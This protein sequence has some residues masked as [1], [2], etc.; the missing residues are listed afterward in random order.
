[1]LE[2]FFC[3]EVFNLMIATTQM[4]EIP[5]LV[6]KS[7]THHTK[8][9]A[10]VIGS[11]IRSMFSL[12]EL[13]TGLPADYPIPI[14]IVQHRCK[15]S[16]NLLEEV[17]QQ[18]CRIK[19]KQ[20]QEKELIQESTVYLAPPDY[21]LL[22]EKDKT[23]SLLAT[24]PTNFNRPSIDTLF[25][26]AAEVFGGELIGILLAGTNNDGMAGLDCI[27]K[28]GGM[29]I[30]QCLGDAIIPVL[31]TMNPRLNA[32]PC[33]WTLQQIRTYLIEKTL[34]YSYEK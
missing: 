30:T 9:I 10:I 16:G 7:K 5:N 3:T 17:L 28:N 14:L 20:A 23:F 19:I 24:L 11:S 1:V 31:P 8:F 26:S 29:I 4:I 18:K 2:V 12:S 21:H 27:H 33:E 15:D 32:A 22:I 34:V 25:Q 13:L 6:N